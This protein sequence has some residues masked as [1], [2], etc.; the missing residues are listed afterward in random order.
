MNHL[1]K[2]LLI[3]ALNHGA[4]TLDSWSTQRL[5][6]RYPNG[7]EA[8]PLAR[9]FVHSAAV[10]FVSQPDAFLADYML[11]KRARTRTRRV[12]FDFT[13]LGIA[14][15][16]FSAAA[17]NLMLSGR[18]QNVFTQEGSSTTPAVNPSPHRILIPRTGPVFIPGA[19][20]PL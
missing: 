12:I 18:P 14:G 1:V 11:L 20:A 9:P 4:A 13:G 10:Y 7:R 16:H 6:A 17:H 15:L 2:V 3:V 8:N 5:V 19:R